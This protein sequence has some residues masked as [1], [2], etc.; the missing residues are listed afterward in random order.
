MHDDSPS[1]DRSDAQLVGRLAGAGKS[2]AD[3]RTAIDETYGG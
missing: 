2:L 1:L 3:V